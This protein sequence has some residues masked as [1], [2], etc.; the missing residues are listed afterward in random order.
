MSKRGVRP[1]GVLHRAGQ[2]PV[3][4]ECPVCG[5]LTADTSFGTGDV[6]CPSCGAER[7]GRRIFPPERLRR[8]DARIRRYHSDGES[9]IVVILVAT[10]LETLLE[11][12]LAR[13]MESQGASLKLRA[14]VLDTQRSVG[15]RLGRLFPTLTSVTFEDSAAE[16]GFRDFPKRWRALRASRN[17]FIHDSAFEAP[18]QNLDTRTA[19]EAMALLDQAYRL[20]VHLNNRFAIRPD[21]VA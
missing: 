6:T 2:P 10:F 15:Q 13:I 7:D 3:Y 11:D 19:S 9:E 4:Y 8:L 12:I 18:I 1:K 21:V 5:F 20:F 16:E 17:A 14:S